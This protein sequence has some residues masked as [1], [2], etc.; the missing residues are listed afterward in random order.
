MVRTR[1]LVVEASESGAGPEDE[2]EPT[3]LDYARVL[4]GGRWVIM[5]IVFAAIAG[6]IGISLI[7]PKSYTAKAT[8][9]PLGPDRGAGLSAL[10]GAL[11]GALSMDSPGAKL[12]AVLQSRTVA[13]DVVG[14]LNLEPVLG[15]GRGSQPPRAELIEYFQKRVLKVSTSQGMIVV[16][17][18]W[19]DP[20]LAAGIANAAVLSAARYLNEHS[21]STSF[22]I[23]DEAVPPVKPSGPNV[24]LNV[25]VALVS[26]SM[27]AVF[28]VFIR[29]HLRELRR[30]E[31]A[32]AV[33]RIGGDSSGLE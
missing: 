13:E 12:T 23:L 28:I 11:S 5:A 15:A 8:L 33:E 18:V 19:R 4:W 7:M 25:A 31:A 26:S 14:K 17:A 21:I 2:R 1:E 10:S 6:A 3:I 22:Q 20:D 27:A 24:V 30:A 9:M 29:Q 32:S 16:K